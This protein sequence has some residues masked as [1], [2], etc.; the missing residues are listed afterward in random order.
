MATSSSESST[1]IADSSVTNGRRPLSL[2]AGAL[3][4]LLSTMWAGNPVANKAGLEDAGPLRLGYLRF[5]LGAIVVLIYAIATRQSFRVLRHEWVPL[6]LLGLLFTVQLA[7]MNIGQDFTTA[8]HAVVVTTTFPL[9]AAVF[10][11]F[12]V[13]G[14]RMSRSRTFG[15]MIAYG[16]VVAVFYK[17]FAD[18]S[19]DFLIGD[20]L[21]LGSAILLGGRQV[22]LSQLGQGIEQ[23]KLLMAQSIFGIV[24]FIIASLIFEGDEAFVVTTKLV[25]A[26]FYTGV[27]IAGLGFI[28]QT[29][30]LKRYLPSRVT[31][32][33]LSQ[34][35][36][37]VLLSWWILGEPI[38]GELYVGAV[39]VVAGSALAQRR[40]DPKT[41]S[42]EPAGDASR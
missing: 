36:F 41:T 12:V 20:L 40:S 23:H 33:S 3:A 1:K 15:T 25:I 14:D 5:I 21:L 22:L 37:G 30:L 2:R 16:G 19:S 17:G 35:I 6:G 26:L 28:G 39:L 7:F 9:W 27:L 42:P 11:H 18:S 31:V 29:W 24:T 13:P 34:P 38:G 4:L 8:G 10:A 32:I